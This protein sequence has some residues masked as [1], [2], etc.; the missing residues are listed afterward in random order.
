MGNSHCVREYKIFDP[1]DAS[2]A[3]YGSDLLDAS[4]TKRG[5]EWWMVLAGQS[6]G[7]GATDLFSANLPHGSA[8]SSVGWTPLRDGAGQLAPLCARSR[9]TPW[10]GKGG[11]HCPSYVKGWD[12][13]KEAWVE[14]IYYAGASENL[15]GPY[16]IGFLEWDGEQ[17]EDQ[18]L[19]VFVADERWEHSSVYEPNLVY[20]DGKW[21]MWYVGGSNHEDYLV[22]GYSESV[23][24]RT[25]WSRHA[26]FA[27][28]EMKMF[29]FCVRRQGDGFEAVFARVWMGRGEMSPDT[30]L[31]WCRAKE[32]FG[33]FS[34]W[35]QPIQ[36]MTAEDRGWH[37]GPWKPSHQSEDETGRR[38]FVFFDGMYGTGEPGP[39]PFAFT[40][41]CAEIELPTHV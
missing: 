21:K 40:L 15:W 19:P 22:H 41:G 27:A 9:S 39:F 16:T 28:P 7:Y 30:G 38:R 20:H 13:D 12:P 17:W 1:H 35:S 36:I 5:E 26:V 33:R 29:D 10:D 3:A 32:P 4:V 24:G 11:R 31:W 34:D 14:R 8:L 2:T 18:P 37:A 25:G 23:D 6:G